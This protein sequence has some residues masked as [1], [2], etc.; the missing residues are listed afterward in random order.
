MDCFKITSI[1]F[2]CVIIEFIIGI[3]LYTQS[4]CGT[5]GN[6]DPI[7]TMGGGKPDYPSLVKCQANLDMVDLSKNGQKN[8]AIAFSSLIMIGSIGLLV[9]YFKSIPSFGGSGFNHIIIIFL[10]I[11]LM[12]IFGFTASVFSNCL[13]DN[14][15][16]L[17]YNTEAGQTATYYK[18]NSD[19]SFTVSCKDYGYE[20]TDIYR[21]FIAVVIFLIVAVV[22]FLIYVYKTSFHKIS[23]YL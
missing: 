7:I 1:M 16:P 14:C 10:W 13:K 20:P 9:L 5:P 3:Y 15:Q 19:G 11:I 8:A 23:K 18:V 17:T 6:C 12:L 22:S 4:Y 21:T 2:V